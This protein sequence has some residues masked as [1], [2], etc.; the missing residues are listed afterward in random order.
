V[1]VL[2]DPA[3]LLAS[4][5]RAAIAEEVA[6]VLRHDMR[7][8]LAVVRNAAV[9]IRKRLSST[10]AW[11]AEPRLET[12]AGVIDAEIAAANTL[13]AERMNLSH[14][15]ARQVEAV[16]AGPCLELAVA[17]ARL[18]SGLVV[19]LVVDSGN[20]QA[21]A[22]E[23]A[24]ALRCL[25]E[26]AAEAC[27]SAVHVRG[28]ASGAEYRFEVEDDGP[29]LAADRIAESFQAFFTTKEGHAGLGLSVA[30]RVVERLR[31][32]LRLSAAPAGGVLAV[33]SLPI[34]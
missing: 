13:L 23:L 3:H 29:G 18:P 19:D 7:N 25:V 32:S 27:R 33:A 8:R 26:N 6:S 10:E 16:N 5:E 20:V 28:R 17:A 12:F 2:R 11:R 21:D 4:A 15:F 30:K 14:L 9:F 34:G 22:T 24:L 31:G 1:T